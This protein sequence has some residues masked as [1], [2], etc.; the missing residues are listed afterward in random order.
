MKPELQ[1]MT[2]IEMADKAA[3]RRRPPGHRDKQVRNDIPIVLGNKKLPRT[4]AVLN[5]CPASLC[6]SALLGLCQLRDIGQCYARQEERVWAGTCLPSRFAMMGYWDTREAWSIASDILAY[7][8]AK[9]TKIKAL[10]I[11]ECGDFRHFGDVEKAEMLARFLARSG[12]ITY[13]YTSR[14]DL[15]FSD[16]EHLVV[17]GSGWMAHNRFQVAYSLTSPEKGKWL[18][19]DKDG[20]KVECQYVCPGDCRKC[21]VCLFRRGRTTAVLLH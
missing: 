6:P 4:T 14:R 12:I 20:N 15:D 8:A 7:N 3:R 13:C 19:E 21:S 2:E 16:C 9:K 1:K 11:N 5:L 18:A 17:N 10:R